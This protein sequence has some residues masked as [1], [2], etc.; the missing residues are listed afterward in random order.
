MCN[1]GGC[2][3]EKRG[4]RQPYLDS[5]GDK[6]NLRTCGPPG[7]R[8]PLTTLVLKEGYRNAQKGRRRPGG[9]VKKVVSEP[10]QA[11]APQPRLYWLEG[12]NHNQLG[13]S[14]RGKLALSWDSLFIWEMRAR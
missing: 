5:L 12:A 4:H 11:G 7:R 8:G 1:R 9:A 14:Q 10:I 6:V 13:R 3:P 2:R